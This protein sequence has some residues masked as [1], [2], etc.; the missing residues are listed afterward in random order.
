MSRRTVI[1]IIVILC[2]V[3]AGVLV[4]TF[5]VLKAKVPEATPESLVSAQNKA[6]ALTFPSMSPS[7]SPSSG[8]SSSPAASLAISIQSSHMRYKKTFP[9]G[10][11]LAE[12]QSGLDTEGNQIQT[13]VLEVKLK[14]PKV[15]WVE[16]MNKATGN[17]VSQ[18]TYVATHV[19]L[20]RP[21][22]ITE[23]EFQSWIE[24]AQGKILGR[25]GDRTVR[26]GV[27]MG[28]GDP[29]P[30]DLLHAV[31][32]LKERLEKESGGR[33]VVDFDYVRFTR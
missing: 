7:S 18:E 25:V 29:S 15:K 28:D 32:R 1:I 6:S 9:E 8:L 30:Q 19:L 17:V 2:V 23:E 21:E 31:D 11:V 27:V 16:K 3:I 14:Y 20:E 12:E 24:R 33:G 22:N 4:N 5:Q 26:V 10:K 13:Q